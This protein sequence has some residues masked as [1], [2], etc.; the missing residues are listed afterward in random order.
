MTL[1]P[2]PLKKNVRV[3]YSEG[4]AASLLGVSVQQLRS[5]VTDLVAQED[6]EVSHAT[7][8]PSDLVV[9]RILA[10]QQLNAVDR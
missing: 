9:L 3:Q 1:Q 2:V 8:Q 5:L 4:E 7:F 6:A 10:G